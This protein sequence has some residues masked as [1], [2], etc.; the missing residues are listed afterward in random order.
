MKYNTTQLELKAHIEK[1][2]ADNAAKVESG[3]Y[4]FASEVS[5]DL[6]EWASEGVYSIDDFIRSGLIHSYSDCHKDAYGFRP[7]CDYRAKSTEELQA[8]M[9]KF[10]E[11]AIEEAKRKAEREVSN[12]TAIKA[13]MS[14]SKLNPT[15]ALLEILKEKD[16]HEEYDVSYVQYCLGVGYDNLKNEIREALHLNNVETIS[17]VG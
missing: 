10:G 1:I 16:L 2:N 15:E 8:D 11:I 4:Y 13:R 9:D 7:T 3:E 17:T 14:H 6:D 12:V 5:T